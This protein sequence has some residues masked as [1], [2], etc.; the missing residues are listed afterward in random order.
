[1]YLFIFPSTY[2]AFAL[3]AVRSVS[4]RRTGGSFLKATLQLWRTELSGEGL[5][6]T[7]GNGVICNYSSPYWAGDLNVPVISEPAA[8]LGPGGLASIE[9]HW[10][11]GSITGP[12]RGA[13]PGDNPASNFKALL[14]VAHLLGIKK[15]CGTRL[16]SFQAFRCFITVMYRVSPSQRVWW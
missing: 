11:G 16:G 14:K 1:M 13:W 15:R 3:R 8:H 6:L 10:G 4:A 12:W 5:Q 2:L 7:T 9:H